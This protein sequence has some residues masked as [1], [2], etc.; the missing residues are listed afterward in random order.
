MAAATAAASAEVECRLPRACCSK[1]GSKVASWMS[2]VAPRPAATSAGQG[3]VSPASGA[4]RAAGGCRVNRAMC[5]I[6]ATRTSS[7]QIAVR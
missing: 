2:S 7:L 5:P 1:H 6:Q 3:R 4:V